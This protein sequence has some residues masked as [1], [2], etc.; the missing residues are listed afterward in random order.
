VISFLLRKRQKNDL[1]CQFLIA[2]QRNYTVTELSE[3]V[4]GKPAHDSITRWLESDHLTPA[5]LWHG[6]KSEIDPR[7]GVLIID[8]TVF[9]KW[10]SD[11]MGLVYRQYSGTHHTQVNGIGLTS[12]V[13]YAHNQHIPIDYRLFDPKTD[14]KTR[15]EHARDMLKTAKERAFKPGWVLMDSEFSAL[16]TLKLI[17]S[18]GWK[19]VSGIDKNR[20]VTFVAH[21]HHQVQNIPIPKV[22]CVVHLKGFGM[23]RV[24]KIEA[25][26]RIDYLVTND[27]TISA[28]AV[29]KVYARRWEVEVFHRG[30]K[31]TTGVA[32]CQARLARAQRNHIFCALR[33]FLSLEKQA[34]RTGYSLYAQKKNVIEEAIS[35][36]LR[37]PTVP[38]V[39]I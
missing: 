29:E 7:S 18:F 26:K 1:Y 21:Q 23:V 5:M 33:V 38:L 34:V 3:R 24:F 30:L 19:F 20:L 37:G 14:G 15:N 4:G 2:A 31:Q 35:L 13:W 25:E 32:Q 10:Y 17:H 27:V 16:A 9:D 39:T 11:K 28:S 6:I 22:G 36:Y 12:M 8:H